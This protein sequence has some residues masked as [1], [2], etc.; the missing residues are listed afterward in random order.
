MRTRLFI[1]VALCALAAAQN[2]AEGKTPADCSG[3]DPQNQTPLKPW[4]RPA[5]GACSVQTKTVEGVQYTLPDPT[6]TPGAVNTTVTAAILGR[7]GFR[8]TCIRNRASSQ[9][10][11][12]VVYEWYGI[13][14]PHPGCTLDHLVPLELGGADT[15]DNLWP[16]CAPEGASVDQKDWVENDLAAQVRAGVK[17]LGEAQAGIAADWTAYLPQAVAHRR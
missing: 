1:V 14:K 4:T 12:R 11:K 6:C 9:A 7:S 10:G 5:L 3:V 2:I 8:T 17:P 15:L 16:Q 13:A